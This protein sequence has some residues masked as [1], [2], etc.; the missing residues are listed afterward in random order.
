MQTAL[1]ELQQLLTTDYYVAVINDDMQT[2]LEQIKTVVESVITSTSTNRGPGRRS[3]PRGFHHCLEIDFA[4]IDKAEDST[5][6]KTLPEVYRAPSRKKA[7]RT[8]RQRAR[9]AGFNGK[10][11][12]LLMEG[13]DCR[14]DIC[15]QGFRLG[16]DPRYCR[17][18]LIT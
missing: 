12:P 11:H 7:G 4:S 10:R 5:K 3:E 1:D 15:G 8:A 18:D 17:L 6:A 2:A 13:I 14:L 16:S 9:K